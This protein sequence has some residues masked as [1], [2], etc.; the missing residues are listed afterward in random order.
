MSDQGDD[1]TE[2]WREHRD[3]SKAKRADNRENGLA[4]LKKHELH[5]EVKNGGAHLI[6]KQAAM[7]IDY[8][9][10]TGQWMVRH[11]EKRSRGIFTLLKH[12]GKT[13]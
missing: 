4:L 12:L 6:V 7:V 13:K 10:G 5:V 2:L 11:S 3:A 1:V 9:P 8:W